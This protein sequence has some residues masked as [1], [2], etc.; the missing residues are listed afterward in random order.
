MHVPH[1]ELHGNFVFYRP[2]F[3]P[4]TEHQNCRVSAFQI[5]QWLAI[6]LSS[7]KKT[8]KEQNEFWNELSLAQLRIVPSILEPKPLTIA[9]KHSQTGLINLPS[10]IRMHLFQI[11]HYHHDF[12]SS[13]MIVPLMHLCYLQTVCAIYKCLCHLYLNNTV[14]FRTCTKCCIEAPNVLPKVSVI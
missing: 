2:V 12:L 10:I 13:P 14:Q 8:T 11:L 7:T 5:H 9:W 4:C 6:M 3:T 1:V